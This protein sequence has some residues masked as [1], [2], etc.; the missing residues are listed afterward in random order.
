MF[1][2][3]TLRVPLVVAP[4]AGGPS[5]PALAAA[6]TGAGALGFLA[7]GNLTAARMI[8]QLDE[9]HVLGARVFGLNVFVPAAVNRAEPGIQAT[10]ARAAAVDRYRASLRGEVKRY[11]VDLG[12]ADAT[13][14]DEWD[15]KIDRLLSHPVPVVSF[16]FGLPERAVIDALHGVGTHVTVTVTSVREA[17]AS[18]DGGADSLAVQGPLA[19][20][21]G[22]RTGSAMN[23]RS[24]RSTTCCTRLPRSA[25]CRRS[26]PAAS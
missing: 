4:M 22:A 21:I 17:A 7:A 3:R 18:T 2:Y 11:G 26:P 15:A 14:T 6:A 9:L 5:T 1:D 23:P 12:T 10:A 20:G 19:G 8:A 13:D 25:I 24:S 16:T